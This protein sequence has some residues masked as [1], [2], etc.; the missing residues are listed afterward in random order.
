[1]DKKRKNCLAK[2]RRRNPKQGAGEFGLCECGCGGEGV[3]VPT[4]ELFEFLEA[5]RTERDVAA[6]RECLHAQ[7]RGDAEAALEAYRRGLQIYGSPQEETL[8][9]LV[10]LGPMAPPWN[11][12][13]WI[14]S[15]AYGCPDGPHMFASRPLEVDEVTAYRAGTLASGPGL[16][17]WHVG[18]GFHDGR[19]AEGVGR[20]TAHVLDDRLMEYLPAS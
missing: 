2:Q 12:A 3:S 6:M 11:L 8:E 18:S 7:A 17:G 5:N 9:T 19:I 14:A 15:Q 1:M 13:R 20:R 4:G 16:P 10:M